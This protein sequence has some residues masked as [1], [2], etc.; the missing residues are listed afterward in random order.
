MTEYPAH[1]WPSVLA[2][3][4]SL[5]GANAHFAPMRDFVERLAT[6]RY[7][8]ALYPQ[9]SMHTLRLSQLPTVSA[10]AEQLSISYED[11]EFV[12]RYQGGPTAP[13]WTKRHADGMIA[14]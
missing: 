12:V 9:Q 5:A 1:T 13:V 11:R 4:R 7:G 6:S 14:L 3:F 10:E 8:P 2:S